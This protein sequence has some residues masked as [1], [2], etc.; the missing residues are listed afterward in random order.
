VRPERIVLHPASSAPAGQVLRATVSRAIYHGDHLRL[1]CD[2]GAGQ[3]LA[4]VR[5]ALSSV[6]ISA[7]PQPGDAVGLEFPPESTRIYTAP[8]LH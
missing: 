7:L 5:L 8:A 6:G 1:M 2:V 3:S 4:T